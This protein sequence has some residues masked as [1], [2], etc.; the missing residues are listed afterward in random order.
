[1]LWEGAQALPIFDRVADFIEHRRLEH[2]I[3]APVPGE[4]DPV[5]SLY[6]LYRAHSHPDDASGTSQLA[7]SQEHFDQAE[8]SRVSTALLT[9]ASS[10]STSTIPSSTIPTSAAP[11]PEPQQQERGPQFVSRYVPA[12]AFANANREREQ[13]SEPSIH[14]LFAVYEPG[15]PSHESHKS[16]RALQQPLTYHGGRI[17]MSPLPFSTPQPPS[18]PKLQAHHKTQQG[19]LPKNRLGNAQLPQNDTHN[20]ETASPSPPITLSHR[21][22]KSL[23]ATE[24]ARLTQDLAS[25]LP[26]SPLFRIQEIIA[27]I[28]HDIKYHVT[29]KLHVSSSLPGYR[30]R[31]L[32]A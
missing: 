24:R 1:L 20:P 4:N 25:R 22:C 5:I 6:A 9:A 31:A 12:D 27:F 21:T 29:L 15:L 11:V 23:V 3:R 10:T 2:K 18:F 7:G 26:N 14:D 32:L 8:D 30:F 16:A 13:T 19:R 17:T 28:T